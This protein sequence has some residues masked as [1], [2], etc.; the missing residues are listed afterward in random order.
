MRPLAAALPVELSSDGRLISVELELNLAR[1]QIIAAMQQISYR[2]YEAL[3]TCPP[4]SH[5]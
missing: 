2:G 4:S 5:K 3:L 1:R